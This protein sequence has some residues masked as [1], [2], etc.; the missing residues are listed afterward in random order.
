MIE[1]LEERQGPPRGSQVKAMH[2]NDWKGCSQDPPFPKPHLRVGSGSKGVLLEIPLHLR[3]SEGKQLVSFISVEF[4]L[5]LI[6]C[7]QRLCHPAIITWYLHWYS[8]TFMLSVWGMFGE[9]RG[10]CIHSLNSSYALLICKKIKWCCDVSHKS[11]SRMEAKLSYLT[12][13]T[14]FK[15]RCFCLHTGKLDENKNEEWLLS[16]KSNC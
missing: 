7:I 1:H 12:Y 10:L 11:A 3:P 15:C 13:F 5:I 2:L 14:F 8:I 6:S 9:W 4:G 16:D